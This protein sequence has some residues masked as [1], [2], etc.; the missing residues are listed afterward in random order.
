MTV[1]RG[2]VWAV[3][4]HNGAPY[5]M[6]KHPIVPHSHITLAYDVELSDWSPWVGV[7]FPAQMISQH[8][9]DR[10]HAIKFA[11][12]DTIPFQLTVRHMT[13]S[14]IEGASP[15][16]STRMILNSQPQAIEI[17]DLYRPFRIEFRK[18]KEN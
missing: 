18:F 17:D 8:W 13:V 3:P 16:E 10:V 1:S 14:R 4:I 6:P 5:V 9:N 11:F 12:L 15:I 2:I 7:E